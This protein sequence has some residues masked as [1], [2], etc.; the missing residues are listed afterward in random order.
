[1]GVSHLK[2]MMCCELLSSEDCNESLEMED[3]SEEND[4]S[5]PVSISK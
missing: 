1:M 5:A 2:M 4:E 3:R